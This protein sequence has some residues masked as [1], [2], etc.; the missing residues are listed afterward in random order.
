MTKKTI[1]QPLSKM[2]L[3]SFFEPYRQAF[4]DWS[5]EHD[6]MLS[7]QNGPIRQGI[8]LYGL[9]YAAY[10][11]EHF[12]EIQ[13]AIPDGC[14]LLN[15]SLDIKH[16]QV[17]RREHETKWPL[18]LKAMEEQFLPPIR[19]PLNVTE[20]LRF[21]EEEAARD[22]I[23]NINYLTGL[24]VLNAYVANAERAIYW[25]CRVEESAANL[26]RP[27]GDWETR[28]RLFILEL[29]HAIKT[30]KEREFLS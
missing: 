30:G 13:F 19:Q 7:R 25:C 6:L 5:V 12:I 1:Y 20:V 27:L 23:E 24:A 17:E 29:Q 22:R 21:A 14:S 15:Q 26:G 18:V 28:K 11:P 2:E 8:F 9:S 16:R 3:K 10:R 4:P